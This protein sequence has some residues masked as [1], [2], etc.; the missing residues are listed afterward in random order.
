MDASTLLII[1]IGGI[2]AFG[3]YVVGSMCGAKGLVAGLLVAVVVFFA[4]SNKEVMADF[5][6]G[7][8]TKSLGDTTKVIEDP[9]AAFKR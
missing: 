4:V 5:V 8:I 3:L 9:T 2:F 1:V 7:T 6:T